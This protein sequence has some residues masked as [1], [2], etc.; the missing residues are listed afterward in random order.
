VIAPVA[1][2]LLMY[3]EDESKVGQVVAGALS[4]K[5]L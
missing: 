4:E 5:F 2:K 1:N 3:I